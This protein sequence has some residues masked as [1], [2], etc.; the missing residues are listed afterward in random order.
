[1]L[2]LVLLSP[3][4][5]RPIPPHPVVLIPLSTH[6]VLL[7]RHVAYIGSIRTAQNLAAWVQEY[8]MD[9]VDVGKYPNHRH[10]TISCTKNASDF[11]DLQAFDAGTG[12]AENWL[13]TFT[14][15]LR[16]LL[17]EGQY[18]IS[19]ARKCSADYVVPGTKDYIALAPWFQGG[20]RWGGGGFL[21]VDSSVGSLIDFY[22]VQ[23]YNRKC[24]ALVDHLSF[25]QSSNRGHHR[26]YHLR[27]PTH[28]F[29]ERLAPVL[30]YSKSLQ[31]VFLRT[32]LSLES[33]PLQR[34]PATATSILVLSLLVSARPFL[35]AGKVESWYVS[36]KTSQSL[37]ISNTINL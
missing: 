29:V 33:Q 12:S 10:Y 37:C 7:I 34:M 26:I 23:F 14:K 4:S 35:R 19:H 18:I 30:L 22:N 15:E 25:S 3:H 5:V 20:G 13:I 27:W 1:M 31:Q 8:D 2:E 36:M 16:S 28:R 11:E 6:V 21:K 9:G 24:Y 32:S 17:P